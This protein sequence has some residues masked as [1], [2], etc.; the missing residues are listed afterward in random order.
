MLKYN[1]CATYLA[2]NHVKKAFLPAKPITGRINLLLTKAPALPCFVKRLYFA[3]TMYNIV[4]KSCNLIAIFYHNAILELHNYQPVGIVLGNCL[5]GLHAQPSGRIFKGHIRSI[6][7]QL[8][9]RLVKEDHFVMPPAVVQVCMQFAW[10]VIARMQG[11]GCLWVE[12]SDQWSRR[13]LLDVLTSN[14]PVLSAAD[15]S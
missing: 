7:G 14:Q 10:A 8:L 3:G 4:D 11:D 12:E 15:V 2:V 9:G 13:S 5:Y 1:T 6:D